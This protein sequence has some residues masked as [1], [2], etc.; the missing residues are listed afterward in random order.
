[1]HTRICC[2]LCRCTRMHTCL[3]VW[4]HP[5]AWVC[6]CARACAHGRVTA[7]VGVWGAPMGTRVCALGMNVSLCAC[8]CVCARKGAHC[9]VRCALFVGPARAWRNHCYCRGIGMPATCVSTHTLVM[10]VSVRV[11]VLV[12][13]PV[14]AHAFPRARLRMCLCVRAQCMCRERAPGCMHC[15][16][17]GTP[18]RGVGASSVHVRVLHALV[19][20]RVLACVCVLSNPHAGGGSAWS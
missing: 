15:M 19:I 11:C 4:V 12:S 16:C 5:R 20:R 10:S 17:Q 8:M 2:T 1:M 7:I 3:R 6:V 14:G 18:I 9:Y 13:V